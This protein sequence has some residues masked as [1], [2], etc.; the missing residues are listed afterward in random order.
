MLDV[1]DVLTLAGQEAG[2]FATANPLSDYVGHAISDL[3]QTVV[4][5]VP[6][7]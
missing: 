5:P 2:V 7:V 3:H 6:P 4:H 1:I